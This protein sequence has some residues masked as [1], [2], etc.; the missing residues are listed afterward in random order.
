MP[1]TNRAATV[2][3]KQAA[4]GVTSGEEKNPPRYRQAIKIEILMDK[5]AGCDFCEMVRLTWGV[6]QAVL[7]P[8]SSAPSLKDRGCA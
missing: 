6:M 1:T 5:T 8:A 3:E 2:S 4:S 7:I